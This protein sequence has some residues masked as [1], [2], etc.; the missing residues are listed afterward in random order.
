MCK[1]QKKKN[2]DESELPPN[3][4]AKQNNCHRSPHNL[5]NKIDAAKAEDLTTDE[6]SQTQPTKQ[7]YNHVLQLMI[8]SMYDHSVFVFACFWLGLCVLCL[9]VVCLFTMSKKKNRQTKK[10]NV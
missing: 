3:K 4:V 2:R 7:K 9:C 6:E 1:M 10:N 5:N 8:Q